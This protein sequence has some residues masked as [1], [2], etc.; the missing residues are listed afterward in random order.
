VSQRFQFDPSFRIP[1]G[2][3]A[4]YHP[5]QFTGFLPYCNKETPTVKY[6]FLMTVILAI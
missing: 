6:Q 3:Q 1:T 2:E 5:N 4:Q